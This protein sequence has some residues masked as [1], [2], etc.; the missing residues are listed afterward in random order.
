MEGSG[1]EERR[2]A[3]G[4]EK[5]VDEDESDNSR[6]D[7]DSLA[8]LQIH[9]PGTVTLT[10]WQF[11]RLEILSKDVEHPQPRV[12]HSAIVW[13]NHCYLWGGFHVETLI[14][15]P[16]VLF[17]EPAPDSKVRLILIFINLTGRKIGKK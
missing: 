12:D 2:K 14:T 7:E 9:L 17:A 6:P 10:S 8:T 4:K 3:K 11:M 15:S 1:L 16:D 13:E 5:V